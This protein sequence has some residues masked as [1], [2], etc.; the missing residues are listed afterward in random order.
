MRSS[1]I[2]SSSSSRSSA[3]FVKGNCPHLFPVH[4]QDELLTEQL[5]ET[6]QKVQI[7]EDQNSFL[8][9]M[10]NEDMQPQHAALEAPA[11]MAP[12][13]LFGGFFPEEEAALT[14]LQLWPELTQPSSLHDY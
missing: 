2:L 14:S 4:M 1:T 12:P 5:D 8:R 13:T 11:V 6:R 7:L 3:K 9:H 10:M